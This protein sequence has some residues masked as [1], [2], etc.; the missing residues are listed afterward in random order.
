MQKR[1]QRSRRGEIGIVGK[2]K[3]IDD[4]NG[5]RP[6]FENLDVGFDLSG[7]Y[8]LRCK[9]RLLLDEIGSRLRP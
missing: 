5:N 9:K 7:I 8:S 3:L 2:F 6:R 1:G 4:C